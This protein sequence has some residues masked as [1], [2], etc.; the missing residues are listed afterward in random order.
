MPVETAGKARRQ[1]TSRSPAPAGADLRQ[2][3]MPTSCAR[4][5]LPA[6]L[7]LH[8]SLS[9]FVSVQQVE[10]RY[11]TRLLFGGELERDTGVGLLTSLSC[12]VLSAIWGPRRPDL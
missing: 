2:E 1:G 10:V 11:Q 7:S 12:K 6:T 8:P 3:L 4:L 5:S 9:K